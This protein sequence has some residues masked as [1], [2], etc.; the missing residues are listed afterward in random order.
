MVFEYKQMNYLLPFT[1]GQYLNHNILQFTQHFSICLLELYVNLSYCVN[2]FTSC[3][4][5]HLMF[6]INVFL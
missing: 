1:A 6:I 3:N 5:D 2:I 4:T